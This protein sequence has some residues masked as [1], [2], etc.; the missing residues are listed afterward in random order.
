MRLVGALDGATPLSLRVLPQSRIRRTRVANPD[1]VSVVE[2]HATTELVVLILRGVSVLSHRVNSPSSRAV[3]RASEL[4]LTQK[5]DGPD[6]DRRSQGD[7]WPLKQRS[8]RRVLV[9]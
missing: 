3:E 5:A 7:D 1:V 9:V 2:R 8:G 4:R 6:G